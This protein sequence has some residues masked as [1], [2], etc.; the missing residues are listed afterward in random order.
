MF[1][2]GSCFCLSEI[3][4][5]PNPHFEARIPIQENQLIS[6]SVTLSLTPTIYRKEVGTTGNDSLTAACLPRMREQG[7]EPWMIVPVE[8][9]ESWRGLVALLRE[10][11]RLGRS[12]SLQT[13]KC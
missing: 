7:I 13:A 3:A 5:S 4:A 9:D 12:L 6:S 10:R 8:V 11:V 1:G 2:L